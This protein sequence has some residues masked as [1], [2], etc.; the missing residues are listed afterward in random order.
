MILLYHFSVY[1][2]GMHHCTKVSVQ[3]L[4]FSVQAGECF[5]FLGTNGAGKTTTLSKLSGEES[6]LMELLLFLAKIYVPIPGLLVGIDEEVEILLKDGA[7]I[8]IGKVSLLISDALRHESF[9]IP[10][11]V[12]KV[13][14]YKV[15][16]KYLKSSLDCNETFA[17]KEEQINSDEEVEILLKDGATI[18]IG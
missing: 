13:G 7:A 17:F 3:S 8:T 1:P 4:T 10:Y 14:R 12:V 18:T 16:T 6:Q 15:A 2:G 11:V 5:G 9:G